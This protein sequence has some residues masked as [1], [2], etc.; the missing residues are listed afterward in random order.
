MAL[1]ISLATSVSLLDRLGY[2]D[3]GCETLLLALANRVEALGGNLN[4][5]VYGSNEP[6]EEFNLQF[7]LSVVKSITAETQRA[8]DSL[9]QG[10]QHWAVWF[11]GIQQTGFLPESSRKGLKVSLPNIPFLQDAYK[12]SKEEKRVRRTRNTK[13]GEKGKGRALVKVLSKREYLAKYIPEIFFSEEYKLRT[14]DILPATRARRNPRYVEH[15]KGVIQSIQLQHQAIWPVLEEIWTPLFGAPSMDLE[16]YPVVNRTGG[17]RVLEYRDAKWKAIV[18][19]ASEKMSEITK[20]LVDMEVGDRASTIVE[21]WRCVGEALDVFSG[22]PRAPSF[23]SL[24][25]LV[26]DKRPVTKA[27][28]SDWVRRTQTIFNV[29]K[30]WPLDNIKTAIFREPKDGSKE[31]Y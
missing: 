21:A 13:V 11:R 10:G 14:G 27:F 18:T 4:Q 23:T 12:V 31:L 16:A 22:I 15:Y 20:R 26:P 17:L 25:D 30:M 19:E 6:L 9:L 3:T 2:Q 28:G 29:L 5:V 1:I 7:A 8:V 24:A